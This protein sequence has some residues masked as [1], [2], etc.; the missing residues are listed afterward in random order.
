VSRT[1]SLTVTPPA[2]A[3]TLASLTLN[4][5][6]VDGGDDSIGTVTLSAPA[7]AGGAV[8]NLSSS[9]N[10]DASVPSSV[11]IPAGSTSR[12]FTVSTDRVDR[13]TTVTITATR[14]GVTKTANLTITS[15][16]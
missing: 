9:N 4:P 16:R 11:T 12:T 7:P 13:T 8:V 6:T 15:G 5:T 10:S 2:P 3:G 14:G 1:A